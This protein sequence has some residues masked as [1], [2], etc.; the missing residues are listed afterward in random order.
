[1][2]EK[3]LNLSTCMQLA[4]PMAAPLTHLFD[5]ACTRCDLC[6][7]RTQVVPGHGNKNADLFLLGEAP[8]AKE[9][10]GGEPFIGQAGKL[11]TQALKIAG[12]SREEVYISNLVRC[13]PP[14][15]RNPKIGEIAACA[16][17]LETELSALEP[18]IICTLGMIPAKTLLGRPIRLKDEVGKTHTIP[19]GESDR[20]VIVSYHPAACLY[21]RTLLDTFQ[22]TIQEAA[23]L[24]R[25]P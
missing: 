15:N 7:S 17:F 10:A 13:R 23:R 24:S 18:K 14:K 19:V 8:G 12:V 3:C 5:L 21:N 11:L 6:H 4:F 9:D 20:K 1:M 22:K 16:P 2:V 25:L